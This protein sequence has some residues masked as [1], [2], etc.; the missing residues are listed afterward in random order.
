MEK[1]DGQIME[2][3][4]VDVTK[5]EDTTMEKDTMK[6]D[7]SKMENDTM[8]KDETEK[9]QIGIFERYDSS[10]LVNANTGN[11]VL[12]FAADW[13]PTCKILKQDINSKSQ[14]IPSELT[15]LE[16]KYDNASNATQ[17]EIDLQQKYGVT[18]QHT[19]VQV[20]A[21]GNLI[22]KWNNSYSLEELLAELG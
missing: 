11:V 14:N 18:Y 5:D 10:K 21:D 15:I 7:D 4:T 3:K 8:L 6:K 1:S 9:S 22:K 17:E 2:D 12:F 16:V 20:D 19:L 13:C